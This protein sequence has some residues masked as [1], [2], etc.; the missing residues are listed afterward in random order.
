MRTKKRSVGCSRPTQIGRGRGATSRW[1]QAQGARAGAGRRPGRVGRS[2][3]RDAAERPAGGA[4]LEAAVRGEE[5][6]G[7]VQPRREHLVESGRCRSP[8][9]TRRAGRRWRA[10]AA[11]RRGG[12]RS[13]GS[14]QAGGTCGEA[15]RLGLLG[16]DGGSA[17]PCAVATRIGPR[18]EVPESYLCPVSDPDAISC[19]RAWTRR[20]DRRRRHRAGFEDG[21]T[22]GRSRSPRRVLPTRG[23]LRGRLPRWP[24]SRSRCS[25]TPTPIF[26][27]GRRWRWSRALALALRLVHR[28][29]ASSTRRRSS[30]AFVPMLLLLPTPLVPLLVLAGW[31]LGRLP[32]AL[33]GGCR[34]RP[35]LI[36]PADCWFALGPA[37]VLVLVRRTRARLGRLA[38]YVLALAVA[39]RLGHHRQHA[40]RVASPTAPPPRLH[41]RAARLASSSCIDALLSPLGLL[42]AFASRAGSLRLPAA[43][44]A[45]RHARRLRARARAAHRAPRSRSPTPPPSARR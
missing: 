23:G 43:D 31:L 33:A 36:I 28:R 21:R 5:V 35:A 44:P 15:L 45:D 37:L 29:R 20:Q 13:G 22:D 2:D 18:A 9:R 7:G 16:T 34:A 38:V 26:E 6:V 10:T 14:D 17:L 42:A 4:V 11:K 3:G 40:A 19:R 25:R 12:G 1:R 30:S 41:V 39:V 27:P 32:E 8:A 24:P